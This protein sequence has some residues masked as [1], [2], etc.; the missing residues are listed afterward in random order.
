[1]AAGKGKT[2]QTQRKGGKYE[3]LGFLLLVAGIGTCFASSTIGAILIAVGFIVFIAG[4]F[5]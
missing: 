3:A 5:M 1:M 2:V 4:R